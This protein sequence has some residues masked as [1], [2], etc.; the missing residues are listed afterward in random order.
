MDTL[1]FEINELFMVGWCNTLQASV[2]RL[3][4]SRRRTSVFDLLNGGWVSAVRDLQFQ[5]VCRIKE[6]LRNFGFK[7]LTFHPL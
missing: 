2:I 6:E 1:E 7:L 3:P 5:L 4:L